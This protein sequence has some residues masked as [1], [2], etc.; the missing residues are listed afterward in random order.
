MAIQ[1][2]LNNLGTSLLNFATKLLCTPN[3]VVAPFVARPTSL[4]LYNMY[5]IY[6]FIHAL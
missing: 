2:T 1:W 5:E 4:E 6:M 3:I